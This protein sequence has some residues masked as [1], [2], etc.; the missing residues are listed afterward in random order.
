[1]HRAQG[2]IG[3]QALGA[4]SS[5]RTATWG[6]EIRIQ[7]THGLLAVLLVGWDAVCGMVVSCGCGC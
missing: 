7:G 6:S 5:G 1:M 4:S 3:E 2:Q